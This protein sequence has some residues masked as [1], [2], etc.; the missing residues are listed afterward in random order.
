MEL[1]SLISLGGMFIAAC[2][3]HRET[4]GFTAVTIGRE[5]VRRFCDE[6]FVTI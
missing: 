5:L 6:R 2:N 3:G 4:L 1:Y